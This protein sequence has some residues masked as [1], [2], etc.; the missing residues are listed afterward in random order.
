MKNIYLNLG[1]NEG[2]D[3]EKFVNSSRYSND[4]EIYCFEANHMLIENIENIIQKYNIKN[5][6]IINKAAWT[7]KGIL[8]LYLGRGKPPHIHK[9]GASIKGGSEA[10]SIMS[11]KISGYLSKDVYT[12]CETLDISNWILKNFSKEDNIIF[13]CDIEGA[14]YDIIDKMKYDGSLDYLNEIWIEFHG[15]KLKNFNMVREFQM[16]EMLK[17]KFGSD[18]FIHK[19][20]QHNIFEKHHHGEV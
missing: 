8:K 16:V 4:F 9:A 14:E 13:T 2:R 7:K 1:T 3:L 11:D 5:A 12:N 20:H 6:K 18:A 19:Y 15:K 17:E 10:S